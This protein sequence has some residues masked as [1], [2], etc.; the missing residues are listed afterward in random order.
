MPNLV[1][2]IGTEE[3][4]AKFMP[5]ALQE[6]AENAK[7]KFAD[8]RIRYESMSVYGTPRRMVLIVSGI[9]DLQEDL[10]EENKGPAKRIAYDAEGKPTKAAEGFARGQ[11]VRV[12][13][14]ILKEIDGTEYV[15]AVI[16]HK[17]KPVE[18]VLPEILKS[19]IFNFHFPKPMRW[20]DK[21]IRFARPIQWIVS[22]LDD[23]VI[24]F[25]L[26][27]IPVGNK[28]MGHRFLSQGEISITHA[29]EYLKKITDEG[30]VVI[31]Q[32]KR[33]DMIRQQIEAIAAKMGGEAII[34]EEL[35][36]EV[37]HLVEYPTALYG[38]FS[39][40]YLTLPKEVLITTMK[41]HQKY[42]PVVNQNGSLLPIFITVRNG[43]SDYIEIVKEGN[44]KVLRARLSD[45][46]FFYEEDQKQPLIEK[47]EKLKTIVF[48]EKL[49][50]IYDKTERIA[51]LAES[52]GKILGLNDED[53]ADLKRT[54]LL[55]KADLVTNMVFEFTELQGIM[56]KDYALHSGEKPEVA[57]GIFEHY[58]PRFAGDILPQTQI[59]RI[60]SIA[61]KI[62]TIAAIFGI[63]ITPTGSQDPYA[64]RRQSLGICYIILDGEMG[65]ILQQIVSLTLDLLTQKGIL[66]EDREKVQEALMEFFKQR[67]RNIMMEKGFSYDV[68]DAVLA[69]GFDDLPD[70]YRRIQAVSKLKQG[71]KFSEIMAAFNRVV[72]LAKKAEGVLAIDEMLLQEPAE[73][74]L[75]ENMITIAEALMNQVGDR[76]YDTAFETLNNFVG[77]INRF[78]ENTM[79]MVEDERVKNNRLAL[80]QR[81]SGLLSVIADLSLL[82]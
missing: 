28:T 7:E 54:A 2:E 76:D 77:P 59:G 55:C 65:L 51:L 23:K 81:I 5:G 16:S 75:F 58:L 82:K 69:T 47:V 78:F 1:F 72:N 41:E 35:L 8:A 71:P 26:E 64:L 62:D 6:L 19:L 34:D 79:V 63:G 60:I 38:T 46:K 22:L 44:E 12:E 36:E 39:E 14:L 67:I 53:L 61:D 3:I 4:P 48:Q 10:L 18:E 32:N 29:D 42:F 31:D 30:K 43:A 11:G 56:G 66:K 21:E 49:G 20:S 27:G 24:Q 13:D 52:F 74:E 45:A 57:Q 25:E 15:F 68:V 70:V 80:L 50:T 9:S 33:R 73:K 17:G 40:E 37:N